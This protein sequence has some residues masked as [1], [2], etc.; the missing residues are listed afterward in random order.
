MSVVTIDI[1]LLVG[2]GV[3]ISVIFASSLAG[4]VYAVNRSNQK[5]YSEREDHSHRKIALLETEVQQLKGQVAML[6]GM[7]NPKEFAVAP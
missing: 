2:S 6:M 3:L 5:F 1:G 7:I 4:A